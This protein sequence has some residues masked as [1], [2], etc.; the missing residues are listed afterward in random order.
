VAH[1]FEDAIASEVRRSHRT[2]R[3]V[4]LVLCEVDRVGD[5]DGQYGSGTG[6]DSVGQV[7]ELLRSS[8]REID[9]VTQVGA[10]QFGILLPETTAAGAALVAERLRT[11][12]SRWS[13]QRGVP[14]TASF[15]VA[16]W[17][18]N[19]DILEDAALALD[20]ARRQGRDCVVVSGDDDLAS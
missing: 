5:L 6:V 10:D 20:D 14:L 19:E 13:P 17:A 11:A 4:S 18:D 3:P 9:L 7:A 16:C 8:A 12:I 1:E 15:G 2:G